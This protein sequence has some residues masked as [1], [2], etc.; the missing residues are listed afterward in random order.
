MKLG[1]KLGVGECISHLGMRM[2]GRLRHVE[3]GLLLS[4][5]LLLI[6]NSSLRVLINGLMHH[7]AWLRG[8]MSLRGR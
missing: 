8:I 5:I 7:L 6:V 3:M 4:C 1:N 2:V